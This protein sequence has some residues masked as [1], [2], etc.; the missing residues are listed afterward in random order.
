M[1]VILNESGF[2]S[3]FS[4]WLKKMGIVLK[5]RVEG[6]RVN[7]YGDVILKGGVY[8]FKGDKF[9]GEYMSTFKVGDDNQLI[10]DEHFSNIS[11]TE[12]FKSF[13]FPSDV[14]IKFFTN[15]IQNFLQRRIDDKSI[16][17]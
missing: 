1:K 10:Y 15:K 11:Q 4:E 6:N 16:P 5:Y 13:P 3:I 12:I 17:I 14:L 2:N 9:I 7:G 8:I